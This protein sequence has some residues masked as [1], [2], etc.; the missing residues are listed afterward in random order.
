MQGHAS[1]WQAL[2]GLHRYTTE[3]VQRDFANSK[4]TGS[5]DCRDV[6][7]G[8]RRREQVVCL[9]RGG[10]HVE[11]H[12]LMVSDSRQDQW[13]PFTAFPVLHSDTRHLIEIVAVQTWPHGLEAWVRS[14][15]VSDGRPL[16]WFDTHHW[17]SSKRLSRGGR[18]EASLAALAY[19]LQLADLQP[20]PWP[21][22]DSPL[23][24]CGGQNNPDDWRF[25]ST[26]AALM[27]F[28]HDGD[29]YYRLTMSF[30]HPGRTS[31]DL[32]IYVAKRTLNGY[33]PRLGDKVC[34]A[35]WLQGRIAEAG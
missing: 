19:S 34:G 13:L 27:T 30:R 20:E 22:E 16:T 3:L 26:I 35:F 31:L 8:S 25:Q 15:L 33:R 12:L 6:F 24:P 28:R 11:H 2:C 21:R 4:L 14:R 23:L 7:S 18:I 9:C 17:N 1:H 29:T 10:R 32:P 5:A